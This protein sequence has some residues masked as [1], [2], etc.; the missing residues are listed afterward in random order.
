M[1]GLKVAKKMPKCVECIWEDGLHAKFS[2]LW[3]R[4]NTPK[5]P[6]LVHLELDSRPEAVNY[7]RESLQILWP[8]FM[9]S[10]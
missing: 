4:D 6:S 1:L 7:S 5:R 10:K 9:A 8:P 3:L 2:Y